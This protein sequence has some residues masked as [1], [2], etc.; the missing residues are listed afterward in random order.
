MISQFKA[1]QRRF[2]AKT[3]P[4]AL[5]MA[6][7][8]MIGGVSL[9][10]VAQLEEVLVTANRRSVTDVQTTAVSVSAITTNDIDKLSPRDLGD[11]ATLV[12]NF[13]A[14]KPA[15]FNAASFAMRGVG[16]T[17]I[18]VYQ[19]PQVGVTVDDFVIPHIQSQLLE[20]FD[21]EQIEV[22]RGPQGTLFGKNTTGG[23]VNVKT[24]R[25]VLNENS[26]E[27]QGKIENY[28]RHETRIAGNLA[29][30]DTLALRAAGL[31][32]KS[33]GFW[34]AGSEYGPVTAFDPNHPALG[35]TGGGDGRDLGGDD[36]ISGRLKAL[37]EPTPNFTAMAQYEIIRDNGDSPPVANGTPLD[38]P[39]VFNL[40][41]LTKDVGRDP[42]DVGAVTNRDD[43]LMNMSNGHQVDVDGFY[44]NMDWEVGDYTLSSVTGLRKQE[45]ELPSTYTGEAGPN[46]LFDANRVDDRET[47]Q[48]ELRLA[49]NFSGPF[50]YVLGGFYQEDETTFCVVQILGFL[51]LLGVGSSAFG[52][53]T[54]WDNNPQVMCNQQKADNW[55]VFADGSYDIDDKWTISGGIRYTNE[56]KRWTG[57]NQVFF[58][59]LNGGFDPTLTA[60]TFNEVLD[61]ADFDK[62][63]T[64]VFRDSKTW[65]EPTWRLTLS[66]TFSDDHFAYLNYSRG[67]K[68]G[69]Y[70]DQTGSSGTVITARSAAPTDPEIADSLELGL[71][72]TYLDGRMRVNVATFYA[73]YSDAQRD[74]VAE[75]DNPFGGSFQ[76]TRFFNAADLTSYGLEVEASALVTS[77]FTLRGNLGYL[78]SEY[79]QF[80]ADTNFDGVDNVD[81]TNEDV[82]RAPEWQWGLDA[83]YNHT[84]MNGDLD[85]VANVTYED[86]AIFVYSNVA[87]EYHGMTDERT[88]VNASV[89]YTSADERFFARVYGRNL[90][91]KR[92]RVGELPVADLWTM[93]YYGAPR[94]YG[95]EV[96]YKFG[97]R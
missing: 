41:G 17:S 14:A 9:S 45:S 83:I 66:H 38:A 68:S 32:M 73:E 40:L 58:Q 24:K 61:A 6:S 11:I 37:W 92:Y 84:F 71:K 43:L 52:D 46:S 21:I 69:A 85:W 60:D 7:A 35:T 59:Q 75:F 12:P 64:G 2:T 15:G 77:N 27:V 90:T 36:T 95:L 55:A 33:D 30:T 31:Y 91:D 48:Q 5:A 23:V 20:M 26:L 76:E 86:E 82:N 8:P 25:P 1:K 78:H 18:I 50:N 44:L 72:S 22:L 29:V 57:R 42:L 54:F 89:T 88:L 93:S 3:L 13:S 79:D 94:T 10:A 70:N 16:Q 49:S 81:L 19:D 39:V 80:L 34:K 65:K 97:G 63:S 96:G 56:R 74:L 4:L 28:G 47:F 53:P 51:D 62:Y 67:F 87:P